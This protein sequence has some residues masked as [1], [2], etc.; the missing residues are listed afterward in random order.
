MSILK[1]LFSRKKTSH[2]PHTDFWK[3]FQQ[4]ERT[5]FKILKEKQDVEHA[6]VNQVMQRLAA[7]NEGLFLLAGMFND[8]TA[9]LIVTAEGNVKNMVFAQDLISEAPKLRHWRFTALKPPTDISAVSIQMDGGEFNSGN[10]C[11]YPNEHDRYPDEIDITVVH[12]ELNKLNEKSIGHGVYLF[13]DNYLGELEFATTIDNLTVKGPGSVKRETI[14]IGKLKDY[15]IWRQKEF[16]E[17]HD[18]VRHDT[19]NDT[20]DL[21]EAELEDGSPLIAVINTDLLTWESKVSHPW[22]LTVGIGYDGHSSNGMPDTRTSRLLEEIE[23]RLHARLKDFEGYL[24]I[25]RQ[26]ADNLREIYFAC[27]DFRKP[28]KLLQKLTSDY[29][30]K[31]DIRFDIYKDKYWKTFERFTRH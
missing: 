24:N 2:T 12:P 15:L 7:L 4:N 11:F 17:K 20:H 13:L 3:W 14:P 23:G 30:Q 28:V 26:T 18:G 31:A 9:E 29:R 5:F 8:T 6:F 16:I 1:N 21:L 10:L 25:G 19:E 27:R 22:I